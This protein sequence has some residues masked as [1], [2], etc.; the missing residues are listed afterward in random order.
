MHAF[1][2]AEVAQQSPRARVAV[3]R[4]PPLPVA[5]LPAGCALVRLRLGR[6]GC[7]CPRRSGWRRRR[8]T[9]SAPV[10]IDRGHALRAI[11]CPSLGLCVAVDDAGRATISTHP[12][13]GGPGSWS[14]PFAI[15]GGKGLTS[16]SCAST[17]L[18]VAVDGEGRALVSTKPALAGAGSWSGP[19]AIDGAR[20]SLRS[21]VRRWRCASPWTAKAACSS[22]PSPAI[23]RGRFV[24]RTVSDRRAS[25]RSPRSPVPRRALC[26]AVDDE[27]HVAVSTEPTAGASAWH[28][29]L[30]DPSL[31]LVAVS[32]FAAAS[33]VARR[34]RRQRVRQ[35]QRRRRVGAGV[36][37]A[38]AR[39][40]AQRHS[41]CSGRPWRFRVRQPACAWL[42]MARATHSRATI[43]PRRRRAGSRA[44]STPSPPG[45]ER[46]LMRRPKG[47]ARRS[48]RAVASS[49][50]SA[51]TGSLS[52]AV[53]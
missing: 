13:A 43:R 30:I 34:R 53:E 23:R 41:T 16:V 20:R 36:V 40:G 49:R 46:R 38:R 15:D 33:C 19:F 44:A 29:R 22:A 18:C 26:A 37:R 47:S 1:I 2:V 42:S 52:T 6:H 7:L 12:A 10:E 4:A 35:L 28:A 8:W 3:W 24:V 48:T 11:S 50:P 25:E 9:G 51:R 17:A 32:C 31:G 5:V 21:P 39:R 27:G 45:A 14:E